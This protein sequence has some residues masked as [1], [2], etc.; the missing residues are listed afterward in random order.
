MPAIFSS[1]QKSDTNILSLIGNE[2]VVTNAEGVCIESSDHSLIGQQFNVPAIAKKAGAKP[3][4]S[5]SQIKVQSP[6][7]NVDI[8][9]LLDRKNLSRYNLNII[10]KLSS[11]VAQRQLHEMRAFKGSSDDFMTRLVNE[12]NEKNESALQSEATDY[13]L[14]LS[15]NYMTIS[16]KLVGFQEKLDSL[17][18]NYSKEEEI[19]KWRKRIQ[20]AV[21]GFFTRNLTTHVFYRGDDNFAILKACEP[22]EEK[23]I[24]R[25]LKTSFEPIFSRLKF[26]IRDQIVAGVGGC[27]Q[28][29]LHIVRSLKEAELA[30]KVATKLGKK[31]GA[32][33]IDEFG[34]L[35]ILADQDPHKTSQFADKVFDRIKNDVALDTLNVFFA[36][37][38]SI[39]DTA[40]KLKLHRNTVIYRLNRI[41]EL[42]HLNPR[43]LDEAISIKTA[44]LIKQIQ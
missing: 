44:L 13:G 31:E 12:I 42:L 1:P 40:K 18:G 35:S 6:H 3:D 23:R 14:D 8:F 21:N 24:A 11:M 28:G 5:A 7:E 41:N 37:N 39:T 32:F 10:K 25:M 4:Q 2:I 20:S 15:Q 26:S 30:A 16:L 19:D 17:N 22:E 29:A 36:C 33:V 9:L 43:N 27:A 34:I 38:L